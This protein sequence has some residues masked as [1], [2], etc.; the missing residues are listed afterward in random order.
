MVVWRKCTPFCD[1]T[2]ACP[3]HHDILQAIVN[4]TDQL[5]HLSN[6]DVLKNAI[7]KYESIGWNKNSDINDT[8]PGNRLPLIHWAAALGKCNALEWMLNSGFEHNVTVNG[9]GENALHRTILFLYKSRPKFTT[10]ELKP[11][12]RK[13]C[14]LLPSLISLPDLNNETPLHLAANL[15]MT[16]ESRLVFFQT[17]IEVMAL[18]TLEMPEEQ[19]AGTLDRRNGDGNTCLHILASATEK[20]KSDQIKAD[21]A[22]QAIGVLLRAGADKTIMNKNEQSPLDIAIMNGCN[23]IVDELV[24][25]VY[26]AVKNDSPTSTNDPRSLMTMVDIPGRSRASPQQQT[27]LVH[28]TKSITY[29]SADSP[30]SPTRSRSPIK[31]DRKSESP[32]VGSTKFIERERDPMSFVPSSNISIKQEEDQKVDS[33]QNGLYPMSPSSGISD[34]TMSAFDVNSPLL[35][36][37]REAGLLNEVSDLLARAKARDEGQLR[38]YQ[39]QAK[40]LDTQIVYKLKEI[41]RIKQEVEQ[42]RHKRTQCDEEASNLRKKLASCTNAIRE[43]PYSTP[44]NTFSSTPP[45]GTQQPGTSSPSLVPSSS[46]L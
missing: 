26:P 39:Q 46:S 31:M 2:M 27:T 33:S 34:S 29:Y 32:P 36:H 4:C 45:P 37:L 41:D 42:L 3:E 11:K 35:N 44:T 5:G 28:T 9:T 40:D 10:K 8:V 30:K 16:S 6:L 18:Q 19:R 17:A 22:C 13:I 20:I 23:N 15:L 38:R 43:L 21:H 12:F 25:I 14:N 7:E 24:K 1:K